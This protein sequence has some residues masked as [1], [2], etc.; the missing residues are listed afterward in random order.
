MLINQHPTAKYMTLALSIHPLTH[1]SFL[2]HTQK[3]VLL[4]IW[5]FFS[6][7][8]SIVVFLSFSCS[9][10]LQWWANIPTTITSLA[11]HFF[12]PLSVFLS[13]P[14][15]PSLLSLSSPSISYGIHLSAVSQ[16][17]CDL[18]LLV[19]PRGWFA[20]ITALLYLSSTCWKTLLRLHLAVRFRADNLT[21]THAMG[22]KEL[23]V[24]HSYS[25]AQRKMTVFAV[26]GWT[27]SP[28][29]LLDA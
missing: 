1:I 11:L 13:S 27:A 18:S 25:W 7:F 4:C 12:L 24:A 14:S 8:L 22:N 17:R 10:F 3:W 6:L 19:L 23:T 28:C 5:P 21:H 20:E 26:E 2:A 16:P 9:L 15:A 29:S